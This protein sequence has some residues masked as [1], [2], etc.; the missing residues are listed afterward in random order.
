[1]TRSCSGCLVLS[2]GRT[3]DVEIDRQLGFISGPRFYRATFGAPAIRRGTLRP[4]RRPRDRS[5]LDLGASA[6]GRF[7]EPF[8]CHGGAEFAH[9][10]VYRSR[11]VEIDIVRWRWF[12]LQLVSV[13]WGRATPSDAWLP[14]SH[15][16]RGY[17]VPSLAVNP[18]LFTDDR[19]DPTK[20]AGRN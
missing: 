15:A 5:K 19:P 18:D 14:Q 17:N 16:R 3:N 4:N 7:R 8:D 11:S 6:Q 12:R 1:M 10:T 2:A 13:W 20:T 9:P